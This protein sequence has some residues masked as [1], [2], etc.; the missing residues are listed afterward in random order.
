MHSSVV[1]LL[2][3]KYMVRVKDSLA[4]ILFSNNSVIETAHGDWSE[5]LTVLKKK[6]QQ[7]ERGRRKSEQILTSLRKEAGIGLLAKYRKI[8][9]EQTVI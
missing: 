8:I 3:L 9:E 5:N 4:T 6:K 2:W 7:R 1:L